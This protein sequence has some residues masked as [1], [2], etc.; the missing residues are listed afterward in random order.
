[1]VE[2]CDSCCACGSRSLEL[3]AGCGGVELG[4]ELPVGGSG[5]VEFLIA[6]F[7]FQTEFH[8]LLLK[9]D[10]PLLQSVDVFGCAQAGLP[11]CLLTERFGE[12]AFEL[13][14]AR[15]QTGDALLGVEKVRL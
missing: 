10:D 9:A 14:D 5:G 15:G 13:L 8:R 4:H 3:T 2:D 12:P 6:F 11:P 7:E 1:M